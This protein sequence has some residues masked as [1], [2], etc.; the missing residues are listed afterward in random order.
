MQLFHRL[1][2]AAALGAAT[3]S[4]QA[5]LINRGGGMIYDDVQ[6]I[7]W[8]ADWNYALT[9]GY[10][11]ANAIEDDSNTIRANGRVGWDAAN[12]WAASLVYGGFDDWRLPT[13]NTTAS[14]TATAAA[15]IPGSPISTRAP[16]APAARW[17][18]CSTTTWEATRTSPC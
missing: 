7:T 4:A 18:T 2:L 16:T 3:I 15:R 17:A 10:A 6:D 9:S 11:A 12:N 1:A 5:A 14:S 8:L 13:T